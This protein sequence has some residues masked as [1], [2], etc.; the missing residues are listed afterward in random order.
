LRH[1]ALWGEVGQ[2]G[3]CGPQVGLTRD[4]S[5]QDLRGILAGCIDPLF[6]CTGFDWDEGNAIKNWDLHQVAPEEAEEMFFNQPLIVRS[7]VGHSKKEKR[8][9]VLGQSNRGRFLFAAFTIRN[10]L[11]RIISVRDMNKRECAFYE[12]QEK[13]NT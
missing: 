8:Y 1:F 13:E 12:K 2:R 7:D 9:F 11:I 3:S 6:H 4:G 10:S 5:R